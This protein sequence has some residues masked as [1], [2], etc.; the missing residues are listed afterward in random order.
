MS[1][2]PQMSTSDTATSATTIARRTPS[3]DPDAPRETRFSACESRPDEFCSDG[4]RPT[5]SETVTATAAA[6]PRTRRSSPTV[7]VG[8]SDGVSTGT[9]T[10]DEQVGESDARHSTEKTEDE[11]LGQHLRDEPAAAGPERRPDGH[12]LAP[13]HALRQQQVR[14]VRRGDEQHHHDRA[15]RHVDRR[16]KIVAHERPVERIDGDAPGLLERRLQFHQAARSRHASPA[17][18]A[19]G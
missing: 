14:D 11:A 8:G 6:K 2:A 18:P 10:V 1:T 5:T 19:R 15:E 4:S 3:R 12:L 7:A 17:A 16:A 13:R 9:A